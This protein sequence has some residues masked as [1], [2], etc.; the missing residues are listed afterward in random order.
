MK[1]PNLCGFYQNLRKRNIALMLIIPVTNAH[2]AQQAHIIE[3]LTIQS[4]LDVNQLKCG[5]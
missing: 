2:I 4:N 5:I 1:L 3:K